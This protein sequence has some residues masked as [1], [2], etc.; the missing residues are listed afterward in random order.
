MMFLH[1]PQETLIILFSHCSSSLI[2]ILHWPFCCNQFLSLA[3]VISKFFWLIFG[4]STDLT[5]PYWLCELQFMKLA[6]TEWY[7]SPELYYHPLQ[8]QPVPLYKKWTTAQKLT[9]TMWLTQL[10]LTL[11]LNQDQESGNIWISLSDSRYC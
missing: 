11:G 7:P 1:C 4:K 2:C 9:L 3:G 6:H 5:V 8:R 10:C